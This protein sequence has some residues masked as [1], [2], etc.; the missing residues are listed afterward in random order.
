MNPEEK[1]QSAIAII[2]NLNSE[3]EELYRALEDAQKNNRNCEATI[4]RIYAVREQ[5]SKAREALINIEKLT[6]KAGEIA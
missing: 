4:K 3:L 5:G 2:K 1:L 6:C